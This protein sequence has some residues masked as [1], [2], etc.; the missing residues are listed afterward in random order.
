MDPILEAEYA[1]QEV[2]EQER[3]QR[4][5]SYFQT[6]KIEKNNKIIP[7]NKRMEGE[8]NYILKREK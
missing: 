2:Q 8:K 5:P 3:K 6:L 1:G 7:Q 4:R